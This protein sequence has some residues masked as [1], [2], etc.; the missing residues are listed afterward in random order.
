L[1][2]RYR[3]GF[4]GSLTGAPLL[5]PLEGLTLRRSLNQWFAANDV[6]PRVVAEFEDSALMKVF[7]AD[8]RGIFV[9]PT[10]VEREVAEQFEVDV[11]GRTEDIRER[12]YAVSVERR[13]KHP[14]VLAI[15]NT[16]RRELFA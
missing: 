14:A 9:A 12:Y 1:V 3:R 2:G 16:A 6:K 13:L 5:L 4:P 11:L 8:G 10:A 7:G 15:S